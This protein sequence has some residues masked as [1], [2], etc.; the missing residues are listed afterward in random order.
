MRSL[1][2]AFLAAASACAAAFLLQAP[3]ATAA[4]APK[5]EPA[6]P[7]AARDGLP[8]L[9]EKLKAGGPVNIVFLGGSITVGGASPKG[10]VSYVADWFKKSYPDAKINV[11][12]AG[13]S[14]TGSDFGAKRYDRDVLSKDPDLVLVEFCV[15]DGTRDMTMHM[16]RIVHK[17]WQKN[18]KTD[19]LF[20][21]T[22]ANTHLDSYKDGKL[23][24]A[25]SAHERVAAFYGIPTVGTG[26]AAASKINAGEI[27]WDFFSKDGC[28]PTQDGYEIFDAAFASALPELLKTGSPK[29]HELGKSITPNLEVYP[30][31]IAV[32][33]LD[34]SV[35]FESAK[36]EKALKVYPLPVPGVNWIKEPSF[37]GPDGKTLWRLSWMPRNLG[38]K[39]D[40]AIGA[41]KSKWEGNAM[42]WF[43]EDKCFTGPKGTSIF[44]ASGPAT[45]F[46]AS[47][48]ELGVLR[49][50]APAT[51]RYAVSVKSGKIEFWQSDDKSLSLAVLRISWNGGKGEPLAFQKEMKKDGKGLSI[52]FETKL[53]AGEELV[54]IPDLDTPGYI[55]GSWSGFKVLIGCMGENCGCAYWRFNKRRTAEVRRFFVSQGLACEKRQPMSRALFVSGLTLPLS[56]FMSASTL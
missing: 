13:I 38:G 46:G 39:F 30:P 52:D 47:T 25:A 37:D 18:P 19:L 16:E 9:A 10:Y 40:P 17:T 48:G 5:L 31:A 56:S 42:T 6:Q 7:V 27:K 15:N 50:I 43:E 12:N 55:G 34:Y 33:P 35:P 36:G 2:K 32:K 23:P 1:S 26:L 3:C 51:G 4:D 24:P 41:D 14:G 54:F 21:Y 49:F 45:S 11:F 29:A 22:L 44:R 8:N 53:L 20:F 28:H